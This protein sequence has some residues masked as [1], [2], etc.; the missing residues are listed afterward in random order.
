MKKGREL[1]ISK[2][3]PS[4]IS[5]CALVLILHTFSKMFKKLWDVRQKNI[6]YKKDKK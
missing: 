3:N 4:G 2:I 1:L 5:A 6:E